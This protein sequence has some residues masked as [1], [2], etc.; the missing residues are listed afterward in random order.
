MDYMPLKSYSSP[1]SGRSLDPIVL[2]Q[3]SALS[4]EINSGLIAKI[5]KVQFKGIEAENPYTHLMEFHRYCNTVASVLSRPPVLS[6]R[7][8]ARAVAA[9]DLPTSSLAA[10]ALSPLS[11]HAAQLARRPI[12]SPPYI[13]WPA[14]R[15][16]TRF[17]EIPRSPTDDQCS[18]GRR[19]SSRARPTA[20]VSSRAHCPGARLTMNPQRHSLPL[21]R[22]AEANLVTRLSGVDSN[23][24]PNSSEDLHDTQSIDEGKIDKKKAR[25]PSKLKLAS[26][27][28]MPKELERNEFGQ[29][30]GVNSIKYAS[31]LGCM[32]KEFVSYTL[33]GW[34]DVNE[35]V[36]N[37]MW[38]CLQVNYNVEECEKKIIFQKLAKLWRDRKS[39]LQILVREANTGQVASRNLNILKPEFMDQQQ[40]ELFVKRTL[41]PEF[42][43]KSVK[44]RAMREN[45]DHIHTMSRRGYA[46][47]ANIMEK[48]SP[49]DTTIT[50]SQV[51]I[52]GHKKKNGQPISQA[53]GDKIKE[54]E[55]CPP[56]ALNT[57]NIADDAISLVFGK[58]SRGRVRGMGFGVKPSKVGAFVEKNTTVKHLESIVHNLQ[59]EMQ[60][61]RS[62]FQT[63]KSQNEKEQERRGG[64]FDSG[65]PYLESRRSESKRPDL[66]QA[67]RRQR[68]QASEAVR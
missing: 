30:I 45:Q 34:N 40:W 14:V 11:S 63:I 58:E 25:G 49:A 48:E 32:V 62:Y 2:P 37:R 13:S 1:I 53:I 42:Q 22:Q 33:D 38:S 27:H 65:R 59:E 23:T 43:E 52:E 39:K 50:R 20:E 56:E 16:P 67:T 44:F 3:I 19:H 68:N 5:Q 41:S 12:R 7:S 17:H 66:V 46:R 26:G 24:S 31:F 61:M 15:S 35:D 6:P 21:Q 54:I 29:P 8:P 28:L 57:T 10:L 4:F 36:K 60:E 18:L 9:L 55:E 47:L 64:N 51:W